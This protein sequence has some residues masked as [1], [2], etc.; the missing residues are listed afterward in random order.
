MACHTPK[1]GRRVWSRWPPADASPHR[2][3]PGPIAD[4]H[5]APAR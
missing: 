1:P 2:H 4:H 5:E 3:L